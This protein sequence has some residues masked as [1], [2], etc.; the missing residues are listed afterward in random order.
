MIEQ[1]FRIRAEY[2]LN[3]PK[4]ELLHVNNSNLSPI[5][6]AKDQRENHADQDG[7]SER[8][9]KGEVVALVMKVKWKSAEPERQPWSKH[10]QQTDNRHN[11]AH[12]N[13]QSAHLLHG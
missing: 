7:S 6:Q 12:Y 10:E 13:E 8:K 1:T 5:H 3:S 9:V 11:T 4:H 2:F